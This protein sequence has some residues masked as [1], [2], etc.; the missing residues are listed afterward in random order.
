VAVSFLTSAETAELDLERE[1][2]HCR[3]DGIAFSSFPIPDRGIPASYDETMRRVTV[4]GD[5]LAAGK[6]VCI[7]CRQGIGRSALVAACVLVSAHIAPSDAFNAI[8]AA[9]GCPVPETPE[10]REWV[11]TFARRSAAPAV[12]PAPLLRD[13]R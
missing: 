1:A 13:T 12:E 7:H 2:E 5:C 11:E 9:R 3:S 4:L 8:A 6:S 10:Q